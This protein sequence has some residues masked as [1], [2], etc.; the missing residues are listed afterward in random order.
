MIIA[1]VSR[2]E[3]PPECQSLIFRSSQGYAVQIEATN[4]VLDR[5]SATAFARR[6]GTR[7]VVR[8]RYKLDYS[9]VC[10]KF[11]S[12]LQFHQATTQ[13]RVAKHELKPPIVWDLGALIPLMTTKIIN[14]FRPLH[15]FWSPCVA[16]GMVAQ[17]GTARGGP[18]A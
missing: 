9:I 15:G 3:P 5:V 10:N 4:K 13:Y 16:I 7:C 8:L 17:T 2:L 14:N 1:R 12:P 6:Q 18:E 11:G